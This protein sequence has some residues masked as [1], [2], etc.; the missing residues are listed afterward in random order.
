MMSDVP[1]V[2]AKQESH[3]ASHPENIL[4][5]STIPVVKLPVWV[6]DALMRLGRGFSSTYS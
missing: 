6:G 1:N 3:G 5:A 2:L 4:P